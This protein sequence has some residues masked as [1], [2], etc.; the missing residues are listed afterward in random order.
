M[1]AQ[2]TA[3]NASSLTPPGVYYVFCSQDGGLY[4][5]TKAK[6]AHGKL[7]TTLQSTH[8]VNR[9]AF[10]T[11]GFEVGYSVGALAPGLAVLDDHRHMPLAIRALQL[12]SKALGYAMP[13]GLPGSRPGVLDAQTYLTLI[14]WL[15]AHGLD[16]VAQGRASSAAWGSQSG[17][18]PTFTAQVR[19]G[20]LAR[21]RTPLRPASPHVTLQARA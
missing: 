7:T 14:G 2:A 13:A 20:A 3:A 11:S 17:A 21:A 12:H 15:S 5:L 8:A 19:G 18:L 4:K 6:D 9:S 10:A 1:T 16:N